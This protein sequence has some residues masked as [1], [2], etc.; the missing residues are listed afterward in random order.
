M[1]FWNLLVAKCSGKLILQAKTDVRA[2]SNRGSERAKEN[3]LAGWIQTCWRLG[4]NLSCL[5]IGKYIRFHC[6]IIMKQHSSPSLNKANETSND[7]KQQGECYTVVG[8][9]LNMTE[10]HS[11]MELFLFYTRRGTLRFPKR[12][13]RDDKWDL[14]EIGKI[15][16]ISFFSPFCFFISCV[17]STSPQEWFC[18]AASAT[19]VSMTQ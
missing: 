6:W 5:L 8:V 19:S 3:C 7:L 12:G 18:F 15:C 11:H 13:N 4:R 10:I 14:P 9:A 17:K 16:C 2:P 1:W